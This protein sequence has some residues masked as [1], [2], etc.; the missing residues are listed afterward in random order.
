MNFID[1][2]ISVFVLLFAY[3]GL[4]RGLIKELTSLLSLIV[5][6]YIAINF[7]F[8]LEDYLYK[9]LSKYD[10]FVSVISFILVFLTVFLSFKIAGFLIKKM[11]KSLQ[12]GF[13][14]KLF[15]L[16][17]GVSKIALILSILL[18]EIQHLS[19]TFGNI[20]PKKEIKKSVLY[21]PIYNIVPI[22]VPAAKGRKTWGR[23]IKKTI[24]K[25]VKDVEVLISE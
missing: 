15:G 19:N 1:I 17:F 23:K 2:I 12:L 5:G 7:S 8:F 6:V 10:K 20:I 21:E 13:L 9:S 11:V 24:N 3:K 25:T 22:I 4:K 14:D 18:F 16:L